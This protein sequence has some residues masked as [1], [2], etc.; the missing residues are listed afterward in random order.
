MANECMPQAEQGYLRPSSEEAWPRYADDEIAAAVDI[1]R[2]GKV[3]QWTGSHVRSFEEAYA[4]H[5]GRGKAIALANG[6]VAL[7]L[8]LRALGV[9][10]GDEVIVTPRSFVAS[11]FC[12]LLVGAKP[13]FADVDRDSG[14][15]SPATIQAA[16]TP[17]TKAVI[18]VHLGGWPADMPG[19]MNLAE[20]H[21]IKVI[22]D[23]A[24]AHGAEI[25]GNPVGS[26]GDAA[27]FSFCQDKIITT[28]GEGGLTIFADDAAYEYAW[29]FKDHGK[30]RSKALDHGSGA[31]GFRWLHD[32][33]GTNW[34]MLEIS[35]AIG[36]L[37]LGKLSQWRAVRARNAS[38]WADALRQAPSLRVP[39]PPAGVEGAFYK[40][41]AYVDA[42]DP[43]PLRDEIITQA[44]RIGI[45]LFSG[46]CP[47][48]YR[49]WAF[50]DL[51]VERLPVARELGE[52]SLMME[53]HPTLDPVLLNARAKA[54]A[55][56]AADVLATA[57]S[58]R[59]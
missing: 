30:D 43:Q 25:D 21:G 39:L 29:S 58:Q 32:S 20:R 22:E 52:S 5:I 15:M 46:S 48:I 24:Q 53:V 13:V 41:Y 9:G 18:P 16:L 10:P 59:S 27:A 34:R 42:P 12:V 49:E 50:A 38:I 28:A 31:S 7:E 51:A 40:L 23:C 1:L 54:V 33:I 26:F 57:P 36:S 3:N 14:N 11:A 35:A 47:E 44:T 55:S 2:S 37:Q 45:R 17:R 56:I 8:A 4:A 19:I 6:S